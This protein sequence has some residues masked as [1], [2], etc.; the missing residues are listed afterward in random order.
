MFKLTWTPILFF[1]SLLVRG[2][3][4]PR[5]RANLLVKVFL[6]RKYK[7]YLLS[8]LILVN[9]LSLYLYSTNNDAT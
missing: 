8:I 9:P 1:Y 3:K 6:I 2:A 4:T 5:E 7:L